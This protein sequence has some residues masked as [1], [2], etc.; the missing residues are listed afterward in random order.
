MTDASDELSPQTGYVVCASAD[1]ASFNLQVLLDYYQPMMSPHTLGLFLALQQQMSPNP[2]VTNAQ[3]LSSLLMQVNEGFNQVKQGLR[4]LEGLRLLKSYRR[5]HDTDL[6]IFELQPTLTPTE[7]MNDDLL[8]VLCL[9]MVGAE[10]FQKLGQQAKRYQ[11]DVSNFENISHSF[12]DVFKIDQASQTIDDP[13]I[14]QTR[15]SLDELSNHRVDRQSLPADDFDLHFLAQQLADQ[16]VAEQEL[17]QNRHLILTEHLVYGLDEL[18]L[19]KLLAQAV[20]L[21]SGK[22][23]LNRFKT[24]VRAQGDKAQST[25]AAVASKQ[26]ATD[27][28]VIASHNGFSDQEQ[29]LIATCTQSR[30]IDFLAQLKQQTGSGYVSP[31]EKN[32]VER[33]VSNLNPAAVNVLIWY[34]IGERGNSSL[35]A[36]F[37]DAIANNWLKQGVNDAASALS[38]AKNYQ[39][40]RQTL[41]TPRKKTYRRK[42]AVHEKLPKWAQPGYQEEQEEA[43]P[44]Q[45][46][47][48]RRLLMKGEQK[49]KQ[50]K[51]GEKNESSQ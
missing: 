23:D 18:T 3:P 49:N 40:E 51:R 44:E 25:H 11:V 1:F 16:G 45:A 29:A 14:Q 13:V 46:A 37:A 48:M 42:K 27:S 24:L 50:H 9:Q 15:T 32:T 20:D 34:I 47:A 39:K 22:L 2:L 7:F 21:V 33:L 35:S 36:N 30:P 26:P 12:F 17:Q 5:A 19:A 6:L 41:Q 43:S 4:Q 31:A 38:A 8:S 10:R 28:Q